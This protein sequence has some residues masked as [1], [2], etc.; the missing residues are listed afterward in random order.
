MS[1]PTRPAKKTPPK[2]KVEKTKAK[3]LK[4]NKAGESWSN[5]APYIFLAFI[6]IIFL[7]A[8]LR[9]LAIP[10]ERDEGSFAYIGHW[11][12][13]G[14]E[15]YTDMLDS[16]L[17]GLYTIYAMSTTL[18]GYNATGVHLGLFLMNAGAAVF[19]FLLLRDLFDRYVASI[20][21]AFFLI[22]TLSPN[23]NGFAAH[24]TQLLLPF[25]IGG[26]WLFWQGIRSGK[27]LTFMLAG[28]M[29][30]IAFTVKQQAAIFGI[31][32]AV[33]WWPL[34]MSW[35]KKSASHLPILEWLLLGIGGFLPLLMTIGYFAWGGRLD[36]FM[37]WT[38]NQ[39]FALSQSMMDPWYKLLWNSIK[40]VISGFEIVWI[41]ALCGLV[42]LFYS[43]F[44][45]EHALFAALYT[46]LGMLSIAVGVGYYK[47][48]FV[49]T[50]PGIALCSAISIYW[51]AQKTGRYG[52]HIGLAIAFILIMI[53]IVAR[54][55]Y[56][57]T[58]DYA[59]I[60]QEAYNENMFPEIQAIGEE[61]AR[62]VPEGEPIAVLGSEPELLVAAQREGC[63][64]YLMVY[65]MLIDPETAQVMQD[66]YFND[67]TTCG[68]E[69]VVFDVFT[70]SWAPGFEKIPL[71]QKNMEWIQSNFILEGLAEYRKDEPGLILW[72]DEARNHKAQS[73]FLVYVFKRKQ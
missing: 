52:M 31:L 26:C 34:R 68:A 43:G 67:I 45:K 36:D 3:K 48:Y 53:P 41:T 16:K 2:G 24:A 65:A 64:K 11:L 33:I 62:R 58:P 10:L 30:G 49:L 44:K 39:P 13:R 14:K 59:K 55:D 25:L 35:A 29:I 15:L 20:A 51:I 42:L 70:S 63:S 23:V 46:L 54:S 28:L 1:K 12:L 60:H 38:F 40:R 18:F 5:R 61:L 71:H 17:P 37:S 32:L 66:E 69:Y 21:T 57:F 27:L 56:F 22:L 7:Q 72:G 6:T 73:N 4:S 50:M 19:F 47:H 9:L 8:R